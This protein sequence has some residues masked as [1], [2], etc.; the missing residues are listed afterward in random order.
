[1]AVNRAKITPMVSKGRGIFFLVNPKKIQINSKT[2]GKCNT[3]GCHRPNH[4]T[5]LGGSIYE[6]KKQAE[7]QKYR[8]AKN[9][10][11]DPF[12]FKTI[13]GHQLR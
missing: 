11:I 3:T 1:M 10:I 12:I 5:N 13:G 8:K 7:N 9:D 6:S 4:A 2:I